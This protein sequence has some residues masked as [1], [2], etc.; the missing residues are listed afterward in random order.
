MKQNTFIIIGILAIVLV[1]SSLFT[2]HMT[3][4]AIILE[5]QKPKKII[6]EPGLYFKIPFI[7]QVR[8]FSK[9]LLDNDSPPAEV[10]TKDKKNLLID[11]FTVWKIVDPLKFLETVRNAEGAEARLDDILFSEL[12]VEMGTHQLI[13]I[14][15]ET[16]EIIM[17]KVSKEASK[18]ASEY[19]IE[20][21]AIRIKRTD[22]PPEI[23]NSIFNRM[24]T[25]R[26]RIAKEYRSEG[27]EEATKIRAETDKEKTIL[28]ANAYKKEQETRGEGDGIS[29]KIYAEAYQSDPKFYSFM[30]SMEA[31]KNSFKTDTTL[32]MSKESDFLEFLNNPK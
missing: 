23:A 26:E 21:V 17:D 7:Q 4:T 25:E 2:V 3:Q 11:N 32:L 19:G 12:R 28:I 6:T 8:Y 29:T 1:S 27:R 13:D 24:K 30:R 9:Q 10:I 22:L 15:T 5:L 14:V 20:I 16:R 18:K 31:Y